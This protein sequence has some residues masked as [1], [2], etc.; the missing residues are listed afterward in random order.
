[1]VNISGIWLNFTIPTK[2]VAIM[3]SPANEAYVTPT[4]IVFITI[5]KVYIHP[6]IKIAVS[7]VGINNVNPCALFAKPF[8]AVPKITAMSKIKYALKFSIIILYAFLLN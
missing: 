6:T 4:G 1:M 8:A 2:I 5:D 7:I 3:H